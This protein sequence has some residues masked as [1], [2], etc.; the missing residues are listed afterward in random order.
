LL[1]IIITYFLFLT[2]EHF[3]S[4]KELLYK[5]SN[6]SLQVVPMKMT[7]KIKAREAAIVAVVLIMRAQG[8]RSQVLLLQEEVA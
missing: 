5:M 7:W 6:P 8:K 4:K 1:Q 2:K 3:V